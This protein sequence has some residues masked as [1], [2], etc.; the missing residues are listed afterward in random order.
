MMELHP[1]SNIIWLHMHEILEKKPE[2]I[3]KTHLLYDKEIYSLLLFKMNI[4]KIQG[5]NNTECKVENWVD[6]NSSFG[7]KVWCLF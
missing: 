1:K 2:S 3:F 7:L 5:H 4:N 6:K